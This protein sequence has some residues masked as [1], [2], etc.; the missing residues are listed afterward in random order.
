MRL[1]TGLRAMVAVCIL[2][3]GSHALIIGNTDNKAEDVD[4]CATRTPESTGA[5]KNKFGQLPGPPGQTCTSDLC[6]E[7]NTDNYNLHMEL[8]K[9]NQHLIEGD[10]LCQDT[11]ILPGQRV[12][13]KKTKLWKP[14]IKYK[15]EDTFDNQQKKAIRGALKDVE[16]RVQQDTDSCAFSLTEEEHITDDQHILFKKGSG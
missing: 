4:I 11:K 10:I 5:F 1:E 13:T 7:E 6:H 3:H 15:I 14:K 8:K 16:T 12:V 2:F 9:S